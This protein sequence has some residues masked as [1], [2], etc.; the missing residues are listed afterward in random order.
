MARADR[1]RDRGRGARRCSSSG[2]GGD[3]SRGGFVTALLAVLVSEVLLLTTFQVSAFAEP[4]YSGSLGLA[5]D[6]IGPVRETTGRF[7]DLRAGLEQVVDGAVEAYTT[8]H[9]TQPFETD[10]IRV[11][12][13]SDIHASPL[14]MD[15]AR[16]VA[17]GFDVDLVIDTGDLTSFG[18]PVENLIVSQI[19][20]FGRP[21][22]FVRGNHDSIALQAAVAHEPNGIVLDGHAKTIAGLRVFG[23]GDP[24]FTPARGVPVDDEAF[25]EIV[26]SADP[27]VAKDVDAL[28]DPPDLVAVHDDRMAESVAGRVP[29]V[30]SGHFHE[31]SARVENGTLYLRIATTGGSGAGIFR[32]FDIPFTAEI[33]YFS[34]E[35]HPRLIAYDVIEQQ[36][37]SGDLTVKRITLSEEYGDLVLTPSPS[38]TASPSASPSPSPSPSAGSPSSATPSP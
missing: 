36:P 20:S 8:L 33:L 37:D 23:L 29:L 24:A 30:I 3:W 31:T 4:T 34:R 32:G 11:L 27:V 15:F 19:P 16:E 38:V 6:L 2:T 28:Q 25:N 9:T 7:D 12:H 1:G 5:P 26:A 10:A 21:Y 35:E 18:T 17:Q 22:V 13:I 14:G